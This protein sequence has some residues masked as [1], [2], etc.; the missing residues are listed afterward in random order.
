MHKTQRLGFILI[1]FFHSATLTAISMSWID[2]EKKPQLKL[3]FPINERVQGFVDHKARHDSHVLPTNKVDT[4]LL[5]PC[6]NYRPNLE[7]STKLN[8]L[9]PYDVLQR[10][11]KEKANTKRRRYCIYPYFNSLSFSSLFNNIRSKKVTI[12]YSLAWTAALNAEASWDPESTFP[13]GRRLPASPGDFK[14]SIYYLLV[15]TTK[16]CAALADLPR[17]HPAELVWSKGSVWERRPDR[18]SCL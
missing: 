9:M 7:K 14:R 2:Q 11:L 16:G 8:M 1:F 6:V 4:N 5:P 15:V 17:K 3:D 18:R 12:N 10:L 13:G